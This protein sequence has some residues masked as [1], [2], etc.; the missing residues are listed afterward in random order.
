MP[1]LVPVRFPTAGYNKPSRTWN[2]T[3]FHG[4]EQFESVDQMRNQNINKLWYKNMNSNVEDTTS[5]ICKG[6]KYTDSGRQSLT[7][8]LTGGPSSVATQCWPKNCELEK[9]VFIEKLLVTVCKCLTCP[10]Q[11][12]FSF[13]LVWKY[14]VI[15]HNSRAIDIQ[16][17]HLVFKH[18]S[19]SFLPELIHFWLF[20]SQ[21]YFCIFAFTIHHQF[22]LSIVKI[23]WSTWKNNPKLK[24]L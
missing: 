8:P 17:F 11:D 22:I 18:L 13:R 24:P 20:W 19:T 15:F 2:N 21:L 16:M 4:C 6:H 23:K 7:L 9:H 10:G 3:S 12:H 1:P 5:A 14:L